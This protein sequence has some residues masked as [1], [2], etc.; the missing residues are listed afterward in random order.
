M[1][2]DKPVTHFSFA[3]LDNEVKPEPFV[4]TTKASKRVVFPDLYDKEFEEAER[5]FKDFQSAEMSNTAAL[6]KW[7]DEKDYENLRADR[8]TLRQVEVLVQRVQAHYEGTFG[9]TGEGSASAN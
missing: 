1:A 6:R 5:F 9:N 3:D 7:L 8:L 2:N 4:Y